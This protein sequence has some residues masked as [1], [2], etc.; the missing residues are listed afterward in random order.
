MRKRPWLVWAEGGAQWRLSASAAAR[1]WLLG[2]Q[3]A[4]WQVAPHGNLGIKPMEFL[5]CSSHLG[6]RRRKV[7]RASG[8]LD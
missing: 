5:G 8:V 6:I 1:G 7:Q 3:L 4:V 2:N